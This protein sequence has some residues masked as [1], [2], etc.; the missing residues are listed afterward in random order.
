MLVV[1]VLTAVTHAREYT[2]TDRLLAGDKS[3][4]F[5]PLLIPI[6]NQLRIGHKD[7]LTM[8]SDKAVIIVGI[9]KVS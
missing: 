9:Q 2:K 4:S 5:Q 7:F 8:N 1:V 6:I 3:V